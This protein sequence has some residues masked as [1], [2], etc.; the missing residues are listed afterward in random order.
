MA[1]KRHAREEAI[2]Q[3]QANTQLKNDLQHHKKTQKTQ[4]KASSSTV[5][6]IQ[7]PPG[8]IEAQEVVYMGTWPRR[9]HR[10]PKHLDGYNIETP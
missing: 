3:H 2:Q 7:E 1:Q 4:P 6:A 5:E 8:V 9:Q 10:L